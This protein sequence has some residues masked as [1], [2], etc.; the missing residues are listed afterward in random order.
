[1]KSGVLVDRWFFW[2]GNVELSV[3]IIYSVCG[4]KR[5]KCF[6]SFCGGFCWNLVRSFLNKFST[7]SCKRFPPHLNNVSTLNCSLQIRQIWIQLITE[8]NNIAR[9]GVQNMHHWPGSVN[10]DPD[11]P[12]QFSVAVS[13]RPDQWWVFWTPSFAILPTLRN[14]LDSNLVNL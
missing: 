10:D 9:E 8:C 6:C 7:K 14:Q 4:K 1:M 11:W 5:P 3:P 12:T 2:A 13:V